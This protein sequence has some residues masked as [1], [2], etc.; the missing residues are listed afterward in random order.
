MGRFVVPVGECLDTLSGVLDEMQRDPWPREDGTRPQRCAG[1]AL[2]VAVGLL[3]SMVARSGARIMMFMGGPCTVGP[4]Q[5]ASLQLQETMRSHLE[6]QKDRAPLVRGAT[7]YYETLSQRAVAASHV[8]DV[9]AC[10]LDQVGLLEMRSCVEQ[11]G[12]VMVLA[13][14]FGQSVFNESLKRLLQ[15]YPSD[16]PAGEAGHLRM[17]FAATLEVNCSREIKVCG[18]I[19]PCSSL[20]RKSPVVS[21]SEIGQGGTFAWSMGSLSPTTTVA[22][23]F[24]VAN[25]TA[26]PAGKNRFL[27]FVTHYQH[28][29]GK[30]RM[31]VTTVGGPWHAEAAGQ[32]ALAASF[33]QEAAAVIMARIAVHRALTDEMGDIMRW[34]DRTLI[35]LCAR[36]GEYRKDVAESFRLAP[37]FAIFPQFM[38]HLRRSQFLQVF[39]SSPDEAVYYRRALMSENVGNSLVMIQPSLISYSFAGL[40]QPVLLDVTSIKADN[41]LL[42]DTFF[43]VVV[44]HG[45]TVAAWRNAGYHEQPEHANFRLLLETPIADAKQVM[46]GRIPMPRF[47]ICDQ[48]KSQ[49]RFLLARLNPSVT[50]LTMDGAHAPMISDDVS[51][52]VFTDHLVKLAVQS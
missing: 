35:R 8:V 44:H 2:G 17:G 27:Q 15:R 11:T 41:I 22:L 4:G 19:G 50:H 47:I 25:Q 3:E 32:Q 48:H 12:G 5:V 39:N 20:K 33:D 34:L 46:E 1:A 49:A 14:S 29:S 36:F 7:K 23:F 26:L 24:E 43:H 37:E 38:F 51:L 21:E 40:G 16:S 13:D 30:Y 6:L 45:E 31:R 28:S 18:A 10:S 42:L 52:K 9:F